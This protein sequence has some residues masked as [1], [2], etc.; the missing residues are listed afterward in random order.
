LT[1]N[2]QDHP[3]KELAKHFRDVLR[4]ELLATIPTEP[5]GTMIMRKFVPVLG[6]I[7]DER[8]MLDANHF[9]TGQDMKGVVMKLT[10]ERKARDDNVSI[11]A[12]YQ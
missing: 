12:T 7:T 11:Y 8:Q 6:T 2:R 1:Q 9:K 10:C 4:F 3:I 5:A